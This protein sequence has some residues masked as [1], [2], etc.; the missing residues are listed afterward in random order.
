MVKAQIGHNPVNPGI[1]RALKP[2]AGQIYV[3]AQKRLLV[4]ILAIFMRAGQ[5]D[6]KAQHWPVIIANQFLERRGIAL[7]RLADQREIVRPAR[8]ATS[9]QRSDRIA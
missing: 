8:R 3:G 2:E 4:N 6:G 7:L 5:M 9:A 1:E